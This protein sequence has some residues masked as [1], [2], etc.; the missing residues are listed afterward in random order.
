MT[1]TNG[2][3]FQT[4]TRI[5]APRTVEG[6]VSSPL[7]AMSTPSS[8]STRLTMPKSPWYIHAHVVAATAPGTTQGISVMLRAAALP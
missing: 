3:I 6:T 4:L 1:A 2:N 5:N 8:I 7:R